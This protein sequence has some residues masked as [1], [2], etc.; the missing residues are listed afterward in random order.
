MAS[1]NM[2]EL[3]TENKENSLPQEQKT[4][5]SM[6]NSSTKLQPSILFQNISKINCNEK[7]LSVLND[8]RESESS[9]MNI[10]LKSTVDTIPIITPEISDEQLESPKVSKLEHTSNE[11]SDF[12]DSSE[13]ELENIVS[14]NKIIIKAS[15]LFGN[16]KRRKLSMGTSNFNTPKKSKTS[17]VNINQCKQ[18]IN[19][20]SE[21]SSSFSN[22]PICEALKLRQKNIDERDA[23]LASFLSDPEFAEAAEN[24]GLFKQTQERTSSTT[25]RKM[26]RRHTDQSFQFNGHIPL[27]QRKSLRLRDKEPIFKY[28]DLVDEGG[29]SYS[30]KRKMTHSSDDEYEYTDLER[31]IYRPRNRTKHRSKATERT[32]FLNVEDVTE[33]MIK[34]IALKVSQKQY[35]ATGTSCHQCRQKTLDTKT[36]CRDKYCVGVRGQLCGVCLENRYGENA[37]AALKDPNWRCPVCR[38]ICNCSFCRSKAGKRPTG[39]LTPIAQRTGHKSV[40][41][42]LDSLR[43]EG[44][45]YEEA[46]K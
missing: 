24:I 9:K 13:I 20:D 31:V 44:D 34:N 28:E 37:A 33:S 16:V 29:S 45:Y 19:S 5:L 23:F 1:K 6:I 40:K 39:I 3:L 21:L 41:D 43:G 8:Q 15:G 38:G 4:K 42:F 12:S 7:D 25:K 36:F 11:E 32:T 2:S 26:K 17:N 30:K 14:T 18:E 22:S 35:S 27:E 10:Y 46:L